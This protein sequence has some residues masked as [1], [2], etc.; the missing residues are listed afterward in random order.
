[1]YAWIQLEY[2]IFLNNG[3]QYSTGIPILTLYPFFKYHCNADTGGSSIIVLCH[4]T[5][6]AFHAWNYV[7]WR[8]WSR[9]RKFF[10][11]FWN[12]HEQI[13]KTNAVMS[14]IYSFTKDN[15]EFTTDFQIKYKAFIFEFCKGNA[16]VNGYNNLNSPTCNNIHD[17][18]MITLT[19][20]PLFKCDL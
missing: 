3:A 10:G 12:S 7:Q 2:F 18:L 8:K 14:I 1:M 16:Y 20:A 15:K 5:K 11:Y 13:K 17:I 6:I 4:T 19:L 9:S